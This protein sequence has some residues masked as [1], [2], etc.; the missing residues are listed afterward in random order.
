LC[1][2]Q[3]DDYNSNFFNL[4]KFGLEDIEE[5]KPNIF[6]KIWRKFVE[7]IKKIFSA[8]VNFFKFIIN[9]IVS[10]VKWII[11]KLFKKGK[12]K[13]EINSK[14][15]LFEELKDKPLF[16][17]N[18]NSGT[19]AYDDSKTVS[20]LKPQQKHLINICY[21]DADIITKIR[22][23]TEYSKTFV[24]AAI[25]VMEQ[26]IKYDHVIM[27]TV[28]RYNAYGYMADYHKSIKGDAKNLNKDYY[29]RLL[30]LEAEYFGSMNAMAGIKFMDETKSVSPFYEKNSFYNNLDSGFPLK[31]KGGKKLTECIIANRST[32]KTP[33]DLEKQKTDFNNITYGQICSKEFLYK[34]ISLSDDIKKSYTD[35]NKETVGLCKKMMDISKKYYKM[36]EESE[37]AFKNLDFSKID[38]SDVK[39]YKNYIDVMKKRTLNSK[40]L[41]TTIAQITQYSFNIKYTI[42]SISELIEKELD[43][44]IKRRL[45]NIGKTNTLYGN[46]TI[47]SIDPKID[48]IPDKCR[49]ELETLIKNYINTVISKP[50]FKQRIDFQG[51]NYKKDI[52]EVCYVLP[53][54]NKSGSKGLYCTLY[55]SSN[56]KAYIPACG[57]MLK[58]NIPLEVCIASIWIHEATHILQFASISKNDNIIG[59]RFKKLQSTSGVKINNTYNKTLYT[60]NNLKDIK[61]KE[62]EH[63]KDDTTYY[64][65]LFE[66]NANI[67]AYTFVANIIK[68]FKI[69]KSMKSHM[70]KV[71]KKQLIHR[72]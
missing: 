60:E 18:S 23:L 51:I 52:P 5:K 29:L 62:L 13:E 72:I 38:K 43:K 46:L 4:R 32:I 33:D 24:Y 1:K 65:T 50:N 41:I 25:K 30:Q 55:V 49:G 42:L 2:F 57:A 58:A 31:V 54:Q 47:G 63:L 11:N 10:F 9:K 22:R 39:I 59:G 53:G 34:M 67:N 12:S 45:K 14:M 40:T 19:E 70:L 15:E 68:S 35:E 17:E 28:T 21:L 37:K 69:S 16:T 44:N 71:T 66:K 7:I 64:N 6:I 48:N 36:V 61:T 3:E 8:I 26:D 27:T 56:P 20:N